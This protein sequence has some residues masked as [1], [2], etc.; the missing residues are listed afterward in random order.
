MVGWLKRTVGATPRNSAS[1]SCRIGHDACY[2]T[3]RAWHTVVGNMPP[4]KT[5]RNAREYQEK[6]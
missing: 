4:P 5:N 1:P 3:L 2:H 6:T